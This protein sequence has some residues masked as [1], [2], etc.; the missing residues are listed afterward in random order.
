MAKS[1]VDVTSGQSLL[2]V[3]E[4][5]I[6]IDNKSG[7]SRMY[8]PNV[9]KIDVRT[10]STD[11]TLDTR[12]D[13]AEAS[14]L[15]TIVI[16]LVDKNG[17]APDE[18]VDEIYNDV[19]GDKVCLKTQMEACSYGKVKIEPFIGRTPSNLNVKNGVVEVTMDHD[20]NN[21][22]DEN[23][24]WNAAVD[25][26]GDLEDPMFGL[27]MFAYPPD[28]DHYAYAYINAKYSYYSNGL[29]KPVSLQMHE[30]GH[31]FGLAHSGQP[32]QGE[33]GD[34]TGAMGN[35]SGRDDQYI[36]YNA[37]KNYQLGW[38]SDKTDAIDPL[39][40]K[41]SRDF[42]LNGVADYKKN[43]KD[44]LISLR[45]DQTSRVKDYYIGFNRA[46][47]IHRDTNEDE[48]MVTI[49]RKDEGS[50]TQ[51]G[52]S[53]KVASLNVGQS[54][55]IKDF[56]GDGKDVTVE[57]MSVQ[58]SGDDAKIRVVTKAV[59]PTPPPTLPPDCE[60][61]FK[62]EFMTDKYPEDNV[63]EVTNTEGGT[64]ATSA[65]FTEQYKMYSQ[66][67]CLNE[68]ENSMSD[69]FTFTILDSYGDG[70]CCT[71]GEGHYHVYDNCGEK[72]VDSSDMT[73]NFEER[74]YSIKV[75]DGCGPDP[76]PPPPPC[77]DEVKTRFRWSRRRKSKKRTCAFLAKKG[78]CSKKVGNNDL[79]HKGK[80][81]WELCK[82]SCEKCD[83]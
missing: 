7:S 72:L 62:V 64:V 40:G 34:G 57:F 24:A 69:E 16:R 66:L 49:I 74:S 55:M 8:I 75:K 28:G 19:F 79:G 26:I 43:N 6:D 35:G 52:Q 56:N 21:G 27:V 42:I 15:T 18:S 37:Q 54:H 5:I 39:D 13:A 80:F 53:T 12:N 78:K 77:E 83:A 45:L 3:S 11:R 51:Y 9:A 36:C 61:H 38:Y 25:L 47:G 10:T 48:N 60:K 73:G 65:T 22:K 46:K 20:A 33:Y 31:N 14:T 50:P 1:F 4:A 32:G 44:A 41:G 17:L 81:V 68:K 70:V 58:N 71:Y 76:P 63:W 82:E 59:M 67:I 2:T 29:L 23:K 30:V